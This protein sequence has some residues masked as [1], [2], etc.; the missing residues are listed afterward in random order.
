MHGRET[1]RN[2]NLA[3][4]TP[5]SVTNKNTESRIEATLDPLVAIPTKQS[6]TLHY[7][8]SKREA[9][10]GRGMS[11]QNSRRLNSKN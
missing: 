5:Q 6:Q 2:L 8:D 10:G 7:E 1:G 4:V 3:N 11:K 9:I